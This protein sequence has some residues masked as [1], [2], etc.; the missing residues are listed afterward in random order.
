MVRHFFWFGAMVGGALRDVL[1]EGMERGEW[2][3][4]WEESIYLRSRRRSR[5]LVVLELRLRG[6]RRR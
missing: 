3:G 2:M 6:Q 5:R 1:E 4:K